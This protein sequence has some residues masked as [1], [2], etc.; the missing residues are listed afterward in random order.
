ML[1]PW[2]PADAE[3]AVYLTLALAVFVAW[4]LDWSSL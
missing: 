1:M 4:C 3:I 2:L